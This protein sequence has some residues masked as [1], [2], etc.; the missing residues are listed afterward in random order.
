MKK[1]A[2][3]LVV[4]VL[5][6][7]LA[8][9][10]VNLASAPTQI[11][12]AGEDTP[13][14]I[15]RSTPPLGL[16]AG[17]ESEPNS[18][19]SAFADGARDAKRE[20]AAAG[21]TRP[22]GLELLVVAKS[23]GLPVPNAEVFYLRVALSSEEAAHE[24]S[25]HLG[26]TVRAAE[27]SGTR[28][29]ANNEG[30]VSLP[31]PDGRGR[32]FVVGRTKSLCGLVQLDHNSQ[33]P[34]LLE[35]HNDASI[36]V[37][38]VDGAGT[39]R[40]GVPVALRVRRATRFD[41]VIEELTDGEQGLAILSQAG[42]AA[43]LD[44]GARFFAAIAAVVD[45]P[46][47]VEL[48]FAHVPRTPIELVLPPTGEAEVWLKRRDGSVWTEEMEVGLL[49]IAS[50]AADPRIGMPLRKD[51]SVRVRTRSG[52]ALF[53]HVAVGGTLE[54]SAVLPGLGTECRVE[55]HG[56]IAPGERATLILTLD[57]E[58]KD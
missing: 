29:R 12:R 57:A 32:V 2:L 25:R 5:F 40:A 15:D 4:L 21:T 31:W 36:T 11:E 24:I 9:V 48:D 19:R 54:A 45:P 50:G 22:D 49:H 47:E 53:T 16:D 37:Q 30:R 20:R 51:L 1:Y 58:P 8:F 27:T 14:G 26:K 13:A 43:A 42:L 17:G 35:L 6:G 39:P 18:E 56:P 3:L 52:R 10:I 23:T 55:E 46:M 28:V 33:P 7:A 34:V 38:V 41:D 44:D